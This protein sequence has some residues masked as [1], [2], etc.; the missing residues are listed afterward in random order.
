[1]RTHW[2]NFDFFSPN[3]FLGANIVT[4]VYVTLKTTNLKAASVNLLKKN[5]KISRV[6]FI[7][8]YLVHINTCVSRYLQLQ[9]GTLLSYNCL[10]LTPTAHAQLHHL[11]W[12]VT[13]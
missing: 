4:W 11:S 12:E 13:S 5:L 1:M 8:T 3:N 9:V 6:A 2:K 10:F 7:Q